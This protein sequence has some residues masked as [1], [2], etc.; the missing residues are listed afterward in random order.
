MATQTTSELLAQDPYVTQAANRWHAGTARY[1]RADG[2]P[3][4]VTR[5]AAWYRAMETRLYIASLRA[6]QPS[7]AEALRD[8]ADTARIR[9]QHAE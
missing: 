8:L 7:T 4:H 3:G 2:R 5:S 9:A 1:R 6:T